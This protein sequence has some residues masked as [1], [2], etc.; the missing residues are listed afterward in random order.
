MH[1]KESLDCLEVIIIRNMSKA[2]LLRPQEEKRRTGEK[3]SIVLESTHAITSRMLVEICTLK[4]IWSR[5]Q[6]EMSRRLFGTRGK[7]ILLKK[8]QRTWLNCVLVF[9]G[10]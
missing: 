9:C 2:V 4:A 1:A 8:W 7:A 5:S 6:V 3:A 10:R